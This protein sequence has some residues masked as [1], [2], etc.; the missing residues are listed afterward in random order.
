MVVTVTGFSN[1][2]RAIIEHF[3]EWKKFVF[4]FRAVVIHNGLCIHVPKHGSVGLCYL[5]TN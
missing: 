3:P 1:Q 5:T 4:P 2:G